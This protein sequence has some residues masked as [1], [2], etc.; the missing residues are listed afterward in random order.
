MYGLT[1]I[2]LLHFRCC[3]DKVFFNTITWPN[4]VY[5]TLYMDDQMY[6]IIQCCK[7]QYPVLSVLYTIT[8]FL[9]FNS[10]KCHGFV[11][12]LAP[13]CISIINGFVIGTDKVIIHHNHRNQYHNHQLLHNC[14][15]IEQI[16]DDNCNRIGNNR[17]L[18]AV[19]VKRTTTTTHNRVTFPQNDG[20][21]HLRIY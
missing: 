5:I 11:M 12:L 9:T 3:Y 14:C 17:R 16:E 10:L 20:H 15:T 13:A 18:K 19:S 6:D 1:Y 21:K 4:R 8:T 2:L 7:L